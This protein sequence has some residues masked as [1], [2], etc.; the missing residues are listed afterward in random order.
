MSIR[1]MTKVWETFPGGG[2]EML[3][4]LALADWC[5]DTGRSLYPSIRAIADKCRLSDSQARRVVHRMIQDGLLDV[6]GNQ[7]G[8]APGTSRHY[9]F[10]LDR[11]TSSVDAT[12]RTDASRRDSASATPSVD[13]TPR[14]NARDGLHPCAE[15]AGAHA[16]QTANEPSLTIKPS[17]TGVLLVASD[18]DGPSPSRE[19]GTKHVCPHQEIIAAYHEILP[20]SP[21]IRDWTQTR[22]EHLRCR[23]NE[24]QK[25]QNLDWWKR[26]FEYVSQSEF[27]TGRVNSRNRK[28][29]TPGLDW[30][31]KA[32]NFAKVREGRFHD[33]DAAA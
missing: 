11:L 8:G 21:M 2:S 30:L 31:C 20:A 32:E 12:P 3:V 5:D 19:K 9:H 28:P 26:F 22:A 27:L 1:A 24:D 10:R 4:A 17:N 18:A 33:Q 13:A 6:I 16:S 7:F 23:W 29:F 25:R 15:T 14:T